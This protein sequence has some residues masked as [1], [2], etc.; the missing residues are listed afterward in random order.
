MK[1][2]RGEEG[3]EV[4]GEGGAGR[5]EGFFSEFFFPVFQFQFSF[6]QSEVDWAM[7][8]NLIH[9]FISSSS[10]LITHAL[11]FNLPPA[12]TVFAWPED[13]PC[14]PPWLSHTLGWDPRWPDSSERSLV[15]EFPI[16]PELGPSSNR[17]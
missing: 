7:G 10:L 13:R 6:F 16:P 11:Y 8:G 17:G 14:G 5:G 4:G 1:E 9:S 3:R 15:S 12:L 2:E